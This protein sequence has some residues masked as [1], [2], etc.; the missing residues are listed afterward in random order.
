MIFEYLHSAKHNDGLWDTDMNDVVSEFNGF[1]FYLDK[2][3]TSHCVKEQKCMRHTAGCSGSTKEIQVKV[4]LNCL[5]LKVGQGRV[6]KGI[7]GRRRKWF[8]GI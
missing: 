5:G 4:K 2:W 7:T 8:A 6:G 1:E 3:T